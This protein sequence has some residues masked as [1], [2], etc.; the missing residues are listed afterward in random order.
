MAE[1]KHIE[2]ATKDLIDALKATCLRFGLSNGGNEYN[3]IIQVFL[4]KYMNDKFGFEAKKVEAGGYGKRLCSSDKWDKIY[5]SFSEDEV[6]DLFSFLPS[7]TPCLKPEHTISHLYNAMQQ[8]DFSTLFDSTMVDIANLNAGIFSVRTDENTRIPIFKRITEMVADE[9]KRDNFAISLMK[10]IAEFN[11]EAIFSEKYDFFSVIFEYL[12]KDYNKDGGG[13]YA[14]YY[15]PRAVASIMAKLLVPE[16]DNLHS[17]TCYDPA[18]GSGTLL[19]ALAHSI[20]EDR[21][22]IYSQDISEKSSLML[23]L[24]L[25]LNNLVGSIQNVIQGDTLL[26]PAHKENGAI[27]KFDYIVSNPPFN[28]DFSEIRETISKDTTRFWAGVPIIP[29]KKDKMAIYLCFIQHIIYSLKPKGKAAIVVPTGFL[30]KSSSVAKKIREKLINEKMLLGVVAMPSNIFATTG[31]NVSILL[32]DKTNSEGKVCFIDASDLGEKT[33]VDGKQRT[34]LTQDDVEKITNTFICKKEIESFSVLVSYEQLVESKYS[35]LPG[36]YFD[37]KVEH[38]FISEQD[39]NSRMECYIK[40][41]KLLAE[42]ERD[43]DDNLLKELSA[44]NIK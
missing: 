4:Y 39:F 24:N 3:I 18:A 26:A 16:N 1:T 17:V 14:E 40:E 20:G 11:F 27:K 41:L 13:K 10:N 7:G 35:L 5:D 28:L 44:I 9:S 21:C 31:T 30:T 15:T 19:M 38:E 43:A 12:I 32:I 2:Q 6:E 33:K 42:A 22:Q 37:V 29:N 25:I 8:G 36:Q 23:R 34:F